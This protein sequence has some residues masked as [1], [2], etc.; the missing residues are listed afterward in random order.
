M[1]GHEAADSCAQQKHR[2]TLLIKDKEKLCPI[3]D[4][5]E[6]FQNVAMCAASYK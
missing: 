5:K 3:C 4:R 2:S 6:Y 1:A